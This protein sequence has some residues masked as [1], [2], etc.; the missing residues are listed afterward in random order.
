MSM[1]N[2]GDFMYY[3]PYH[4]HVIIYGPLLQSL[5]CLMQSS[6]VMSLDLICKSAQSAE[7]ISHVRFEQ[8]HMK[9]GSS[10][11]I[12]KAISKIIHCIESI[13]LDLLKGR[14]K[15]HFRQY[16]CKSTKQSLGTSQ[17][18]THKVYQRRQKAKSQEGDGKPR[19]NA[20]KGSTS[21]DAQVNGSL[22]NRRLVLAGQW[23]FQAIL[24]SRQKQKIR[25]MFSCPITEI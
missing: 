24:W 12:K 6:Q 19:Q 8:A 15:S 25:R 1:V 16:Q 10:V 9:S 23:A 17:K 13:F 22:C 2:R 21:R 4:C 11:S 18:K 3:I 14:S 7:Q 5:Y 20:N